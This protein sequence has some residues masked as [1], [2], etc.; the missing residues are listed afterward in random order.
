MLWKVF[1]IIFATLLLP[2]C[3]SLDAPLFIAE[4]TTVKK[5]VKTYYK[6]WMW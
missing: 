2:I 6:I 4:G 3:I 5:Y 1:K